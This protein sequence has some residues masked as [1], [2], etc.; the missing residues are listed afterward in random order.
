MQI[1]LEEIIRSSSSKHLDIQSAGQFNNATMH[2]PMDV[3][4]R[5]LGIAKKREVDGP[6][7]IGGRSTTGLSKTI[8]QRPI[9]LRSLSLPPTLGAK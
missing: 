4:L 9:F 8:A 3:T 5:E 6:I 1:G 2:T 7:A